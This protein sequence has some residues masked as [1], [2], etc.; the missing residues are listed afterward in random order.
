MVKDN[1]KSSKD[2]KYKITPKKVFGY[3]H[4]VNKH[5]F[6]VFYLCC[7]AGIPWRGLIHDLSKY[8]I[9][10]FSDGIRHYEKGSNL[11]DNAKK[12]KG[13]SLSWLHHRGRNRHHYEY[14]YDYSAKETSPIIPYKY[15][16]E[17]V[18]DTLVTASAYYGKRKTNDYQLN[19]WLKVRE[20]DKINP[21]IDFLLT[22]IYTDVSE[23][24]VSKTINKKNL[25][26]LY[27]KYIGISNK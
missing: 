11:Y 16:V 18:C 15:L 5:R 21:K 24:G 1:M 27:R 19:Y 13:Y 17:M 12:T 14:W 10:E 20:P 22:K 9:T 4:S 7:R 26:Y 6:Q 23:Q 25:E 8:S 3:F 2:N